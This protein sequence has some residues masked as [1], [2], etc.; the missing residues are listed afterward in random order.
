MSS[1]ET[2]K[3]CSE[4]T[5]EFCWGKRE[6]GLLERSTRRF[7]GREEKGLVGGKQGGV[8]GGSTTGFVQTNR[9]LCF[10]ERLKAVV[11]ASWVSAVGGKPVCKCE[12]KR[13]FTGLK[14]GS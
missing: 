6:D 8:V 3:P 2:T 5:T 9:G 7:V 10:S 1:T 12:K 14:K 13:R 11:V 4:E